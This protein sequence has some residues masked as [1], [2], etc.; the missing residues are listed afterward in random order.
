MPNH[1]PEPFLYLT[2]DAPNGEA[3]LERLRRALDA[4]RIAALLINPGAEP[5]EQS[6][7]GFITLAQSKGVAVLLASE[8]ALARSLGADGVHVPWSANVAKTFAEVRKS[9]VPPL[10]A[11]ADAGRSRHD[12]ME[13]GESGADYVAFG[14][15]PH[16]DDRERAGM[17]RLELV[18]WWAEIFEVPVVAF[19]VESPADAADLIEAGADFIA[20]TLPQSIPAADVPGWI[21]AFSAA[22]PAPHVTF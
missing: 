20:V 11:G 8:P 21:R 22:L 12:A 17:R 14:I 18:A 2:M 19:N 7:K 6:L 9:L 13:I 5:S 4:A 15:P 3:A 1:A 16:V 10:V